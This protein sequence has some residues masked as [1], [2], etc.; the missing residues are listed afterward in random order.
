MTNNPRSMPDPGSIVICSCEDTMPLD[1]KAVGRG[2]RGA[3]VATAR[4]L[5]R[6]ELALARSLAGGAGPL[7]IACTQEAPVFEEVAAEVGRAAPIIYANVRETAGWSREAAAA[8][9]KMAALIAA[10]A[11]PMPP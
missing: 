6:S 3:T 5:C 10:A 9:P 11:E 2:C 1:R 4:N 8:G 7:T